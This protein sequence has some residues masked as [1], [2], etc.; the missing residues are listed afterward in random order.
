MKKRSRKQV[1]TSASRSF[2][3][4]MTP[5]FGSLP[6]LVAGSVVDD[7]EDKLNGPLCG[8]PLLLVEEG[9]TLLKR[10]L[11][12]SV[13]LYKN[14]VLYKDYSDP[15]Y[16]KNQ[17]N[18]VLWTVPC[19]AKKNDMTTTI[20]VRGSLID[21]HK[22]FAIFKNVSKQP[23]RLVINSPRSRVDDMKQAYVRAYRRDVELKP[24]KAHRYVVGW[25]DSTN[26]NTPLAVSYTKDGVKIL[27]FDVMDF[28]LVAPN[29]DEMSGK[30]ASELQDQEIC[31]VTFCQEYLANS[32]YAGSDTSNISLVRS[33]PFAIAKSPLDNIMKETAMSLKGVVNCNLRLSHVGGRSVLMGPRT[34]YGMSD[35]EGRL[36][37]F[38]GT[39]GYYRVVGGNAVLWDVI[40]N[41]HGEQMLEPV[42][43]AAGTG[44]KVLWEDVE[45]DLADI[46]AFLTAV[47]KILTVVASLI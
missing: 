10:D 20:D 14:C 19:V 31:E 45:L 27:S 29:V 28:V 16:T 30:K 1:K 46:I 25:G 33:I 43:I 12:T 5:L 39:V 6:G 3:G 32:S 44:Y 15:A 2:T 42:I 13:F 35:L 9:Q 18:R 47:T 40:N 34:A 21:L 37:V 17:G 41:R 22:T 4:R 26:I 36:V 24:G 38:D 11:A 8:D 23:L 7:A